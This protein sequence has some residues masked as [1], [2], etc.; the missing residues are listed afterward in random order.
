LNAADDARCFSCGRRLPGPL[1]TWVNE[2]FEE[3][4]ADGLPLTKL[5]ALMCL[6]NYAT[7]MI[8]DGPLRLDLSVIGNFKTSSF[9]RFG[10]L[11]G[12]LAFSE[13][14]RLLSAVYLHMGLMHI[15]MNLLAL[16]ALGYQVE[17]RLGSARF[18]I[19][20]TVTG[21]A[22]FVV[23]QWWYGVNGPPTAGAS[24]AVFGLAGVAIGRLLAERDP[25]WTKQLMLNVAGALIW[26][27]ALRAVNNAAHL[28]GLF[29]GVLCSALFE[30]ERRP[31]RREWLM[32]ALAASCLL[33]GVA[34]VV[35]SMRSPVWRQYKQ[36]EDAVREARRIRGLQGH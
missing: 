4:T 19:L 31:Q 15:G 29:A 5:I 30:R 28:G 1:M 36:V 18:A 13:P 9:L 17:R 23:S 20:Y 11:M 2:L 26:G 7:M 32:R 14:F 16:A 27:F 3:W 25:G 10:A 34:S 12:D 21:I 35:L 24:G 22:G 8:A 33:A 6:F